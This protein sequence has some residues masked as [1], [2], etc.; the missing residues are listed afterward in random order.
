MAGL[1]I[2]KFWGGRRMII[3]RSWQAGSAEQA[4]GHGQVPELGPF[5]L[6]VLVGTVFL[7]E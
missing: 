6:G 4:D 3:H 7:S 2:K 1:F 5:V